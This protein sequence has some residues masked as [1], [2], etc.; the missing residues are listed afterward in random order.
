MIVRLVLMDR[1]VE[2]FVCVNSKIQMTNYKQISNYKTQIRKK[3]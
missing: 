2:I 1:I 3:T